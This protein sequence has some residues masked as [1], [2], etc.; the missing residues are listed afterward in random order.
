MPPDRDYNLMDF[1]PDTIVRKAT[2]VL[3]HT[4]TQ[5]I[6]ECV[7]RHIGRCRSLALFMRTTYPV[8]L[9]CVTAPQSAIRLADTSPVHR[10]STPMHRPRG[11]FCDAPYPPD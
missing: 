4:W 7:Q 2:D 3:P 1:A 6:A 8:I 9:D 5:P 11:D 10:R